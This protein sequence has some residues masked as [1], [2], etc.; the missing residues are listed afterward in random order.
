MLPTILQ[1]TKSIFIAPAKLALGVT[2]LDATMGT[3]QFF[4]WLL[5][6]WPGDR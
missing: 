5:I 3:N 4:R 2:D 1:P 6:Y